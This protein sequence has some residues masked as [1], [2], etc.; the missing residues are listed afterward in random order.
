VHECVKW[1]RCFRS[2]CNAIIDGGM[3]AMKGVEHGVPVTRGGFV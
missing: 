1:G 3:D 2:E